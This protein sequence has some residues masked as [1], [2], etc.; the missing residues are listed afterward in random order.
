LQ[1]C[2][3][4][5]SGTTETLVRTDGA[6][7]PVMVVAGVSL[8]ERDLTRITHEWINLKTR[9]HP[10]FKKTGN[11]W[12]DPI[13]KEVKGAKLRKGFRDGATPRERKRAIG[14]LD[15]TIKLLERHDAKILGRVWVKRL[16]AE[17]NERGVYGSSL[18]FICRAFN[19][20]LPAEERGMVVVDSQTY[21]HNHQLAHSVFT[22]RFARNPKHLGLVD[23]PVFGHSDNHA[24][25]QIADLLCSAILAP[26]ACSV[27]AGAYGTWNLH[28][29]SCHLDIRERFGSRLKALTFPT[30]HPLNGSGCSSLLVHDP[31]G[32]GGS[33]LM[34]GLQGTKNLAP[35]NRPNGPPKTKGKAKSKDRPAPTL[36]G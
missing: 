25:L 20:S 23:M 7:Q 13:L 33:S 35:K 15:G 16:D 3:V 5:E 28:C 34:Y 9:F 14:M 2:Y 18:Q 27:Y 8:P 19:S 12:L 17:I 31:I 26:I 29:A 36:R 10:E 1:L 11:G 4:D 22:Q 21:R 24:G 6:Q 30:T 32:K